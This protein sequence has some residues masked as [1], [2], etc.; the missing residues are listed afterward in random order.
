MK[1]PIITNKE[2]HPYLEHFL[3]INAANDNEDEDMW[4]E[5]MNLLQEEENL[6]D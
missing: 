3:V 1:N 5:Y 2:W 4:L 6:E